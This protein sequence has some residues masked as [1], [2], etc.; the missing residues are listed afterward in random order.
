MGP[1]LWIVA[2]VIVLLFGGS[3]LPKLARS[4]GEAKKE[5]EGGQKDASNGTPAT[6]ETKIVETK[7]TETKTEDDK[8]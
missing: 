1:E 5:F 3:Q 2:G 6:P 8:A 7:T 4:L